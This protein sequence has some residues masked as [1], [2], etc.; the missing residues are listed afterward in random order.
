MRMT[1]L[2]ELSENDPFR[3]PHSDYV[4]IYRGNGWYSAPGGYD[5]GPWHDDISAPIIEVDSQGRDLST[6]NPLENADQLI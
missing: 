2:D 6:G 4:W 3:F 1:T 5:G